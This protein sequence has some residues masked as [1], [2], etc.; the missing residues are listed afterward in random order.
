MCR[1]AYA[2]ALLDG[3]GCIS[4]SQ[5]G[6]SYFQLRYYRL[7]VEFM[8]TDRAP[9][10][11][12]AYGWGGVVYICTKK[13]TTGRAMYSWAVSGRRAQEF[14]RDTKKWVVGKREQLELALEF[15]VGNQVSGNGRLSDRDRTRQHDIRIALQGLKKPSLPSPTSPNPGLSSP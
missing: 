4:V 10:D 12:L 13:T 6:A 2:A 8:M 11:E 3:E 7:R 15:P 5:T 1:E 14:L 9:L